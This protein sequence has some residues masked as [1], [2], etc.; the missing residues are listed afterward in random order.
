MI[1]QIDAGNTRIKWRVLDDS[2]VIHQGSQLTASVLAGDNLRLPDVAGVSLGQLSSVAG[3]TVVASLSRQVS[4]EFGITLRVAEVSAT[5]GP[6]TCGYSV[7]AT[8]GVDRWLAVLAVYQKTGRASVVVDAGSAVTIDVIAGDGIHQGGYIVPGIRLLQESLWK[9]T[10]RVKVDQMASDSMQGSGVTTEQAVT[11]GCT[12]ML[13]ALIERLAAEHSADL[14][15]TGGDALLLKA[16]LTPRVDYY[17]DLVL[18]GLSVKGVSFSSG[19]V[20]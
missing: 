7:P 15:I 20:T 6:V 13:I 9:G 18:D 11:R 10:D 3:D 19:A 17:A 1:L 2:K 16:Q 14:V 5:V 12:L 4:R 8:L